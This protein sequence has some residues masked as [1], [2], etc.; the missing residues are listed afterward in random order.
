MP[1]PRLPTATISELLHATLHAIAGPTGQIHRIAALIER[2][3]NNL[4]EEFRPWL[5]HLRTATAHLDESLHAV[6]RYTEA[7]DL[8]HEWIRFPLARVVASAGHCAPST[9]T[10]TW[11]ELPEVECDPRRLDVVFRELFSNAAKF[12]AHQAAVIHVSAT[13]DGQF[14]VVSLTDNGIGI[15]PTQLERIFRP[16]VRLYADRFPGIGMGLAIAR[17]LVETWGGRIWADS[18]PGLSSTFRFTIPAVG[19]LTYSP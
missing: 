6:R 11:D 7:L 19:P 2:R 15:A 14:L 4:D 9:L 13:L 3:G 16:F 5:S 18:V 8:A 1:D 12:C 17:A 10:V